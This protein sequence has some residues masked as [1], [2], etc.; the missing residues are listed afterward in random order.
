MVKSLFKFLS[1]LGV[2]VIVAGCS[3]GGLSSETIKLEQQL[4]TS[5][6]TKPGERWIDGILYE[7]ITER[8]GR[9]TSVLSDD[10]SE[11]TPKPFHPRGELKEG[12]KLPSLQDYSLEQ[13]ANGFR[14]VTRIGDKMYREKNP[15]WDLA[16]LAL[17]PDEPPDGITVSGP[18]EKSKDSIGEAEDVR[19]REQ[20]W[21][22]DAPGQVGSDDNRTIAPSSDPYRAIVSIGTWGVVSGTETVISA[23]CTGVMIHYR[24]VLTAAHCVMDFNGVIRSNLSLTPHQKG[25]R[26]QYPSSWAPHGWI[27]VPNGIAGTRVPAEYV[28]LDNDPGVH[29]D[30]R[31]FAWDY[32]VLVLPSN[33]PGFPGVTPVGYSSNRIPD[34]NSTVM[35]VYGYPAAPTAC[36]T[37]GIYPRLCGHAATFNWANGLFYESRSIDTSGGQS[38]APIW[39]TSDRRS[40]GV[41]IAQWSYW[42]FGRCGF[43][44]CMRNFSRRI[45]NTLKAFM[46]LHSNDF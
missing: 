24:T 8:V 3:D 21:I 20:N 16:R 23:H 38:G 31:F 12:Q 29:Y 37:T 40:M 25:F 4:S 19:S 14:A 13:L 18:P 36:P 1:F 28:D 44:K 5:E 45:D 35:E 22:F 32:A 15:R 6:V 7:D 9:R 27:K 17:E 26:A 41:A 42:D 43:N 39:F 2:G 11:E 33:F 30:E 46:Q 34:E 10:A